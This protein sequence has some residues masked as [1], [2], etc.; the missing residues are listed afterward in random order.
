[1]NLY[2]IYT[3]VEDR[4]K[5]NAWRKQYNDKLKENKL[6]QPSALAGN[7]LNNTAVAAPS[8]SG[9]GSS[10]SGDSK[11]S[12]ISSNKTA[13]VF[14]SIK[15]PYEDTV[16]QKNAQKAADLKRQQE[17]YNAEKLAQKQ[18]E[19]AKAAQ[20]KYAREKY[21]AQMR[22]QQR[23]GQLKG[24]GMQSNAVRSNP[25]TPAV[26]KLNYT[27]GRMEVRSAITQSQWNKV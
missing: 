14:D 7:T 3:T 4:K 11:S 17:K 1:M 26:P 21:I 27:P 9:S 5:A 22:Q 6:N 23:D 18:A 20:E 13:G 8:S 19:E 15:L 16:A 2:D 12:T 10:K 25:F 24:T